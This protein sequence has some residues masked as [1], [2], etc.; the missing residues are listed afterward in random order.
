[1]DGSAVR[2]K[3]LRVSGARK[4]IAQVCLALVILSICR[5]RNRRSRQ[6]HDLPIR[7]I[8]I[9]CKQS[10]QALDSATVPVAAASS[11]TE[12][13]KAVLLSADEIVKQQAQVKSR[14]RGVNKTADDA[15][16]LLHFELD[17]LRAW[18]SR[19]LQSDAAGSDVQIDALR[20]ADHEPAPGTEVLILRLN[21]A[22]Y[23]ARL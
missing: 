20:A 7:F 9:G 15:I 3:A 14:H 21:F 2:E 5:G 11:S 19:L 23:R 4:K 18:Q 1:M 16:D 12:I 13:S 6:R 8:A 10:K 17:K 22:Q